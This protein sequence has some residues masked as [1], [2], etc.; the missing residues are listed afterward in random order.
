MFIELTENPGSTNGDELNAGKE[1]KVMINT[2]KIHS[3][4]PKDPIGTTIV[5][6]TGTLFVKEDYDNVRKLINPNE[7]YMSKVQLLQED[8]FKQQQ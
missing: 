8:L 6:K 4:F 7:D 2:S 3:I 5:L 1:R